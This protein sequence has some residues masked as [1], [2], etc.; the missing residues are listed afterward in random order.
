[1]QCSIQYEKMMELA[2]Y[3]T[4]EDADAWNLWIK[5]EKQKQKQENIDAW[6]LWAQNEK[7]KKMQDFMRQ[8]LQRG[9]NNLLP[10]IPFGFR[11]WFVQ[12]CEAAI[13]QCVASIV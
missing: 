6:A 7:K 10:M 12:S 2:F 5:D 8:E 9:M 4:K 1:M 3:Y 13:E 11:W